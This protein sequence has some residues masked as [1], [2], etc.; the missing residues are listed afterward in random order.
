MILASKKDDR[1]DNVGKVRDKFSIEV[2]KPEE[3]AD[4]LDRGGGLPVFDGRELGW[5]H[6][7]IS[8]TDDHPQIFHGGGVKRAFGDFERKTVFTKASEDATS[9]LVV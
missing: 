7:D 8:L 5:I 6:A 1:G 4:A 9:A 2:C 3:R